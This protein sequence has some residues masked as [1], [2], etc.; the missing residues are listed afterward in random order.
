MKEHILITGGAGFIGSHL[1]D[2]LIKQGHRVTIFDNLHPQVHGHNPQIPDYLNKEAVF[3][4]GDIRDEVAL[5]NALSGITVVFHFAAYTGVGQSMYQIGEYIDVNIRGTAV[6]MELLSQKKNTVRKLI[7][8]SSRAVYG[9]GLYSC[10]THG[11]VHPAPR[12]I[13]QLEQK[14]WEVKCPRCGQDIISVPTSE[15]APLDP[16]SIYA[17][18][19]QGQ[20]Q[21]CHLIGET[22]EIPVVT[23][24]YF[25]VYG[26]RQS[27][28]NPYTGVINV[29]LTRLMNGKPP[30]V[31]EDGRE[32]RDFVHVQDIVQ[33]CMLAMT[34]DKVNGHLVNVGTGQRHSLLQIAQIVAQEL[35]G[36]S[37]VITGQFRVGD[38]RHCYADI[39]AA[40]RL[41]GYRPKVSFDIGL[42]KYIQQISNQ[43]WND[44]SSVAERE[45]TRRGLALPIS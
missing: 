12:P 18:S 41:L 34:T 40:Q 16:Y 29:F 15:N 25:N 35:G 6:L 44:L 28:R 21:I 9:E 37:P 4:Y 10:N 45:L 38:I 39:A 43:Q 24:R 7:L 19:K 8:A 22:Y 23:L 32:L 1:A 13:S 30:Q 11:V 36:P 42:S 27:L 14:Q 26:P 17:I 33:A 20:E 5:L 3:I 31:Y 2:A